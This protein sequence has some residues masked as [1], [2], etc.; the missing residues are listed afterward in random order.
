MGFF[1]QLIGAFRRFFHAREIRTAVTHYVERTGRD[2][3]AKQAYADAGTFRSQLDRLFVLGNATETGELKRIAASVVSTCVMNKYYRPADFLSDVVDALSGRTFLSAERD[4]EGPL[5]ELDDHERSLKLR[6][7][8]EA[9]LVPVKIAS[10]EMLL[11]RFVE[12]I[13]RTLPYAAL[14]R[15]ERQTA[16]LFSM[17]DESEVLFVQQEIEAFLQGW[18]A[19]EA[20]RSRFAEP[21]I[22]LR[23]LVDAAEGRVALAQRTTLRIRRPGLPLRLSTVLPEERQRFLET[24]LEC[25]A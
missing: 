11:Q 5:S 1:D 25:L 23:G 9:W 6:R 4:G 22:A 20:L 13:G 2:A 12:L 15:F 19:H 14:A 7:V 17:L 8:M 18:V 24:A 16:R 3:E 21:G 10:L